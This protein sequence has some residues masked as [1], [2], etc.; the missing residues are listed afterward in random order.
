[1]LTKQKLKY[2]QSLSQKKFRQEERLFIAEGPKI[3]GE[4]LDSSKASIKEYL[5]QKTG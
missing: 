1:M 3:L 2:I 4:V 5:P